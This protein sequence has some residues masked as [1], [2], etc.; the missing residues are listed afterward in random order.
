MQPGGATGGEDGCKDQG[1]PPAT[2]H[3]GRDRD[4][5][6]PSPPPF[7]SPDLSSSEKK[8]EDDEKQQPT[9]D[10]PEGPLVE[11]LSRVPYRSLCRFMCVSKP[12]LALRSHPKIRERW[13]HTL[14][15]FF[16]LDSYG[17]HKQFHN[18][19]GSGPP[20]VDPDLPFLGENSDAIAVQC[21]SSLLLFQCYTMTSEGDRCDYLVCN[22]ATQQREVLPPIVLSDQDDAP[23]F[24]LES[25]VFL[26]FDM[27]AP[28][29]FLV[30]VATSWH[31][32]KSKEV[33]IYS[34]E[35]RR[36]TCVQ[37]EW[38]DGTM[39]PRAGISLPVAMAVVPH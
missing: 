34:S 25:S 36:W 29:S 31:F 27:A 19:S 11:I 28:S 32:N 10:L 18:L 21:C 3:Q 35:T 26:G 22:P 16:Y 13:P 12:W 6:S 2:R 24:S 17:L 23:S 9:A 38:D 39:W 7:P 8:P 5:P 14:S 15:G 37:S 33:A 4:A 1:H 30:F 20:M